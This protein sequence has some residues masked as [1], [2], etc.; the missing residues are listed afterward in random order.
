[1][2]AWKMAYESAFI[3]GTMLLARVKN[4]SCPFLK[5]RTAEAVADFINDG[6]EC[7]LVSGRELNNGVSKGLIGKPPHQQQ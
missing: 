2:T 6:F 3:I 1:M 5:F 4:K 7:E